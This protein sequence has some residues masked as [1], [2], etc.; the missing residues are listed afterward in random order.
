M[1]IMVETILQAS[2]D[3]KD[4]KVWRVILEAIKDHVIKLVAE[5]TGSKEILNALMSLFQ[6]ENMSRKMIL[7]TK[8]RECRMS[9]SNNVTHY[10]MRITQIRD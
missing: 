1:P 2:W 5:K 6:S 7:K 4:I 8:L 10:L 9:T 3:K